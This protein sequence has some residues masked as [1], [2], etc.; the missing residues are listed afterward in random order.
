M[1][2]ILDG[3]GTLQTMICEGFSHSTSASPEYFVLQ[4]RIDSPLRSA[5]RIDSRLNSSLVI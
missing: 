5:G 3:M 4:A 1:S 2:L